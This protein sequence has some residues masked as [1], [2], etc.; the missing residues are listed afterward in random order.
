M[1]YTTLK[2]L[3]WH[4][5]AHHSG[6]VSQQFISSKKKL[7]D[8][9]RGSI[10]TNAQSGAKIPHVSCLSFASKRWREPYGLWLEDETE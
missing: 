6:V 3:A 9:I 8:K 5:T 2:S 4:H 7:E 10:E 1:K